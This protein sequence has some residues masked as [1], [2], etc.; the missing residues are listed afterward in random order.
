MAEASLEQITDVTGSVRG[1]FSTLFNYGDI[2][3]ETAGQTSDISIEDVPYPI[4]SAQKILNAAAE[5]AG[6]EEK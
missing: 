4:Q 5:Y 2:K 1:I 3:I 6:K